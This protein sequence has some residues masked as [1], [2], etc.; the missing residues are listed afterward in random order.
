MKA[1]SM[2]QPMAWAVFHGKDV[3][4]RKWRSRYL[5]TLLIH[6]SKRFDKKHYRWIVDNDNRLCRFIPEDY[7]PVFVQ[8]ALIGICTVVANVSN[9]GS[10]WFTGPYAFVL[11]DQR[12]FETPIPYKGQL[13]LFDVPVDVV[14][15]QIRLT[16]RR[17]YVRQ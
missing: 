15:E 16:Y 17:D 13:G 9:H 5:G 3:E 8:G 12:E 10:R 11:K 7:S 1:L 14:A 2:T 6:A 4:N